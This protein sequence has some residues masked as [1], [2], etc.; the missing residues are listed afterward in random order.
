MARLDDKTVVVTGG[1]HGIGRA[2]CER[3]AR[4]AARVVV[5]DVD[6]AAADAV[7]AGIRQAGGEALAVQTD[8]A[9]WESVQAMARQASDQFGGVDALVNN[10]AVFATI[11]ISR[12]GFEDI[13][14]P[15]WDR[16]ME[17][18]VKGVWLGCRAVVPLMRQRG[19]GSIV[20]I[21]SSTV[22][23]GSPTRLHYVASKA[24]IV[25]LT[26]VLS[27][28]LGDDNIRVNA[29]APGSTLSE[30][31]PTE[32]VLRMRQAMLGRRSIKRVQTP[33]DVIGTVLFLI[34]DDAAF[35][36]GQTLLVDGGETV[37]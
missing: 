10:A 9:R 20:N 14:E 8:V 24:A 19:G 17:V 11:P 12:V 22:F 33:A 6:G 7:A 32:E 26:R 13:P 30:E 31:H 25:G 35:V 28:E 34:S 5:A 3:F 27:R 4:E 1:A 21:S 37:R 36:T 29:V 23:S 16:V 18:N 2:Y 15:E